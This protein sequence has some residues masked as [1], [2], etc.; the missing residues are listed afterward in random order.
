MEQFARIY[1]RTGITIR[2]ED[3]QKALAGVKISDFRQATT[4]IKE[5]S[6]D[7]KET[8]KDEVSLDD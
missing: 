8:S 5:N 4:D 2:P 1:D 6:K 3:M 7:E